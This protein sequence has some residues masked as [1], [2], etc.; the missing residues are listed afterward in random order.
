MAKLPLAVRATDTVHRLVVLGLVGISL[1]GTGGIL[2]NIYANSEYSMLNKN[3][4]KFD[5]AEYE[6]DRAKKTEN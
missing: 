1:V 3:K 6:E 2:F 4:L 5:K